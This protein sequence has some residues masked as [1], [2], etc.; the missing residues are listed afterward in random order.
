MGKP[1]TSVTIGWVVKKSWKEGNKTKEKVV[2]RLFHA[3]GAAAVF[4]TVA[5]KSHVS[6]E[7]ETDVRYY[8][9]NDIGF[10]DLPE[11]M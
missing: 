10:D 6:R 1:T 9:S 11:K 2:S 8:V 7:G 5:E 3:E 4:R